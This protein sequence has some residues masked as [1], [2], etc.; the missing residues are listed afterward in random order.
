MGG[1]Q[2]QPLTLKPTKHFGTLEG[3]GGGGL[4]WGGSR[5]EV[6]GTPTYVSPN[7]PP[8][9]LITLNTHTWGFFKK[10]LH[11]GGSGPDSQVWGGWMVEVRGQK[12]FHIFHA[13][14]DSLSNSEHLEYIHSG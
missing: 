2:V 13:Y 1:V 9:A 8:V 10:F 7:D 11:H 5:A 6:P 12:N 4:G 14:L 3:G